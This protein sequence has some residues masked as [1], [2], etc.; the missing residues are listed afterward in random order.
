LVVVAVT[1]Q[2]PAGAAHAAARA[3]ERWVRPP[4]LTPKERQLLRAIRAWGKHRGAR[5]RHDA[6]LARTARHLVAAVPTRSGERFD[7]ERARA[8][9][10]R[11]GWT[12]GQLAA[13]AVRADADQRAAVE[14][15]L[16]AEISNL[17]VNRVG[18]AVANDAILV[19]LSRRLVNL[20]PVSAR[21]R[22]KTRLHLAG[23]LRPAVG[24]CDTEVQLAIQRPNGT[25]DKTVV[26][27]RGGT[28]ESPV[29]TGKRKGI[30]RI[31]LLLDRGRGPEIA[32]VFPVGVATN[33]HPTNNATAPLPDA[34]ASES[35]EATLVSLIL[36][37]RQAHGLPLPSQS[38]KLSD[39]ARAHARD[40]E[41]Q[42]FFAHVSPTSGDLTDRLRA[43]D[44]PFVRAVENIAAADS[45]EAAFQQWLASP[46]HR[47]NII[48]AEVTTLGVGVAERSD[49]LY[50]VMVLARLAD[51]GGEAALRTRAMRKLNAARERLGLRPLKRD[52]V[53]ERIAGIHTRE[54]AAL[55]RVTDISPVRGYLVDTVFDEADVEEAAADVY[56]ANTVDVVAKSRHLR[57]PF[58]RT[59]VGIHRADGRDG[60]QLWLAVIYA[61]D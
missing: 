43:R 45:I 37:S 61:A 20:E 16:D 10:Q 29:P 42:N 26:P 30:L 46:A 13:V 4:E 40:M 5:I 12:D 6:R 8:I 60:A 23:R 52:P 53:L 15:Q 48:D 33:P 11:W 44:I 1:I 25:I 34:I 55:G 54:I 31:E 27:C 19:L 56:L 39:A 35:A 38:A 50:V 36:G 58:T 59:G 51:Y 22:R 57:E 32:A 24:G 18:V 17:E 9:A 21:V 7:L 47:A 41:S 14:R 3:Y 49:E 2:A 28:F